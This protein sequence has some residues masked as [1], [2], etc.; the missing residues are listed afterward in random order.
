MYHFASVF[1]LFPQCRSLSCT[2]IV[3]YKTNEHIRK[4]VCDNKTNLQAVVYYELNANMHITE[5]CWSCKEFSCRY[6]CNKL[7][8]LKLNGP[9]DAAG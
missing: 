7:K 2:Q 6:F 5:Q 9:D 1:L 4:N 3:Q 8:Y